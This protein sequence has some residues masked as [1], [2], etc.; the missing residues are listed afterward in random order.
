MRPLVPLPVRNGG[1]VALTRAPFGFLTT[2]AH[3]PQ[4]IPQG[5]GAV[6]NV[7]LLPDNLGDALQ[8]PQ[9]G[10]VAPGLRTVPQDLG[11]VGLLLGG[12]IRRSARNGPST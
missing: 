11:Q 5:I 4:E 12:E 3:P 2:P 1:F 6:A 7:K 8:R 9:L 10:L